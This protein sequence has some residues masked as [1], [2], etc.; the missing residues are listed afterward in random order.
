[1][2]MTLYHEILGDAFYDLPGKVQ[3]IHRDGARTVARGHADIK[4]ETNGV[5]RWIAGVFGFP[6]A[7]NNVPVSLH[8]FNGLVIPSLINHFTI[9]SQFIGHFDDHVFGHH[10]CISSHHI[11]QYV[12]LILELSILWERCTASFLLHY[13]AGEHFSIGRQ[14]F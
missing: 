10:F 6:P 2:M 1:M 4:S 12:C 11:L 8:E 3:A 9:Y 13:P 7:G 14:P 5:A